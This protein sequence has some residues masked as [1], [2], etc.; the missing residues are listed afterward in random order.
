MSQQEMRRRRLLAR[1]LALVTMLALVAGL[2]VGSDGMSL[3]GL[4]RWSTTV[5]PVW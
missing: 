4:S 5:R 1:A 3:H 2:L